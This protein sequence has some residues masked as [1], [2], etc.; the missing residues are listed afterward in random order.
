MKKNQS[1]ALLLG[2]FTLCFNAYGQLPKISKPKINVSVPGNSD[3]KASDVGLGGKDP[4]GLFK[5]I[6]NDESAN[7]HRKNAVT[8]LS[9]IESEYAKTSVDYEVLTK[10]MFENERTLGHVMKLEPKVDRS[11]YDAKYLPLKEK[12]D[13]QNAVYVEIVKLEKSFQKDFSAPTEFKKPD[14]LSF[15][16][17]GYSSHAQ[18]Y[19]RNYK[20]EVKTLAD[21]DA[22]KKQ[23]ED[24]SAQLQGYKNTETQKLFSNMATCIANGNNYALF[25]SKENLTKD[26]VE[27]NTANKAAEPTKVIKRCEDYLVA[28][29]KIETDNSLKLEASTITAL[30]QAKA[31]VTKT[32][33]DAET[34]ISS[35]AFKKYQEK[36]NAE[37]IAKVFLPKA[38][39]K[40]ATLEAG[41]I[42]YVKGAE[43]TEYL[44]GRKDSPVASTFRA[45]TATA[46]PYVK[47]NEYGLPLYEYH[48]LWVAF[49]GK[50]G[51]CYRCAVYASYTYKG[52]G[53]YATVPTWGADA[54]EEM[55][56]D[57]VLK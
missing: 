47:K 35:G 2:A 18:C 46:T 27:Y 56:C 39:S 45:I 37:K 16:G 34:Y 9:A 36:L 28:L 57:N 19:C 30:T 52:G 25:A 48:E 53:T 5:N 3:V 8:N 7:V 40:N 42:N 13:K 17:E 49:K 33:T 54:P 43:Y 31:T 32:K 22:L 24:L 23:Y 14:V 26:V 51:K 20:S 12:A 44:T 11:N 4:S 21:Y 38:A 1:I 50:D 15:R 41:A 6:T 10:L 29:T 55:A